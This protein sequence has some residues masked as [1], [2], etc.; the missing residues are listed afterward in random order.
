M[1]SIL[2]PTY[3]YA[4]TKLV[5]DLHAQAKSLGVDFEIVVAEDGSTKFLEENKK[6]ENLNFVH[7]L[8]FTNNVGRGVHINRL[9][10][11]A[12]FDFLL[13]MDCDAEVCNNNFLSNYL[14]FCAENIVI[15]GGTAYDENENN[16]N[17][18][19]RLK[20]GKRREAS[21]ANTR[22]TSKY[23]PFT[24]FNIFIPKQIFNKIRFNEN[25]REYGNEDTLFRHDLLKQNFKI[26]HIDN[27]LIHRGLDDNFIYLQK[28]ET[29]IKNLYRLYQSK[30]FPELKNYSNLL[31][32]FLKLKKL[33]LISI[34]N[35]HFQ[36]F[37]N[38]IIKNLTGKNPSLFLFDL[39]KL[40]YLSELSYSELSR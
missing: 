7:Y 28:S 17:Y 26:I 11:A 19:L 8:P 23:Q 38:L 32:S 35:F 40:G 29:A 18:S 25:I 34:F 6:I 36:F 13:I 22:K 31:N 20:Y 1:L 12:K 21:T 39:Y 9:A 27:Q 24:T 10:D 5:N 37:K 16:P 4:I 33:H 15:I 2:I 30:E 14:S 3:N